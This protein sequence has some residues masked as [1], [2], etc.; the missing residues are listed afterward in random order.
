MD[1]LSF[2]LLMETQHQ[3]LGKVICQ[4]EKKIDLHPQFKQNL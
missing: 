1:L 3:T 2:I 4:K